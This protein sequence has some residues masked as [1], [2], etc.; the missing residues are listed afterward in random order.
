MPE[1]H[2]T[3]WA[4]PNPELFIFNLGY[5]CILWVVLKN[6]KKGSVCLC[7]YT[8]WM[9]VMCRAS[10]LHRLCGGERVLPLGH[11]AWENRACCHKSPRTFAAVI[12]PAPNLKLPSL[13]SASDPGCSA[14]SAP[15]LASS[16]VLEWSMCGFSHLTGCS[17]FS[18]DSWE[19][20]MP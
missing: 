10:A 11:P 19:S 18:R 16:T 17:A 2:W 5:Q 9:L 4:V 3:F 20:C 1:P 7:P 13:N 8:E 14:E 6:N 15:S 12:L